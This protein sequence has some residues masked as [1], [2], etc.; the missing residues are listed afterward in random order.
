MQMLDVAKVLYRQ[1]R[2]M[3]GDNK[4]FRVLRSDTDRFVILTGK[5]PRKLGRY[6]R[7]VLDTVPEVI[8]GQS[9]WHKISNIPRGYHE[10][11]LLRAMEAFDWWPEDV[12]D[13]L[14][15]KRDYFPSVWIATVRDVE[16]PQL[17]YI[18][19]RP[20]V[21]LPDGPPPPGCIDMDAS[22]AP[23]RS[24]ILSRMIR[25]S[26]GAGDSWTPSAAT[27]SIMAAHYDS[28]EQKADPDG[29]K[30][31]QKRPKAK[32]K[33]PKTNPV[34]AAAH[35][36]MTPARE[37]EHKSSTRPGQV[38]SAE[39]EKAER[40]LEKKQE[41]PQPRADVDSPMGVDG[42]DGV[43]NTRVDVKRGRRREGSPVSDPAPTDQTIKKTRKAN[44]PRERSKRNELQMRAQR[45]FVEAMAV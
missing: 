37:M 36:P 31:V 21:M 13:K 22:E 7:R 5:M 8:T 6:Y 16:L 33:K 38:P 32:S 24:S 25:R 40:L 39:E 12:V 3:K 17:F 35:K 14:I 15:D 30:T 29:W 23:D 9:F 2:Y 27:M 28:G 10:E 4:K 34:Q 41:Q 20:C 19:G 42:G 18:N 45:A 44:R 43:P 11:K 1:N 26:D